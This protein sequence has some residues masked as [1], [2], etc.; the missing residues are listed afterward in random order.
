MKIFGMAA[1]TLQTK[2]IVQ[3]LEGHRLVPGQAPANFFFKVGTIPGI[4]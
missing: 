3:C 4:E 1:T 2:C